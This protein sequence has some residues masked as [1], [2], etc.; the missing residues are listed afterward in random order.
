M[1][2]DKTRFSWP[3]VLPFWAVILGFLAMYVPTYLDAA[4]QLWGSD[5]HAHSPLIL[6]VVLFL[7]PVPGP[8]VTAVTAPLQEYVSKIA[9]E[10]LYRAGYPIARSGVI[11]QVGQYQLFV[12]TACSGLNSM[13]SLS[14]MGLL[15]LYL[16]AYRSISRNILLLAS[17]LPFAFLA[18][19][20][21]VMI[22]ILVTY[23][24]GDET[25]QGFLHG[26]AGMVLFVIAL[27][28]LFIWDSV[29]GIFFKEKKGGHE[30]SN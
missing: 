20:I 12:A 16:M 14:A 7:I 4:Q 30:V 27:L 6:L 15:Y 9:E 13:F 19:V 28:L 3:Q 17:I 8:V 24:M 11:L 23:H 5:D 22:L 18:N 26:F 25:A 10:I 1:E 29:L 21:R 2:M